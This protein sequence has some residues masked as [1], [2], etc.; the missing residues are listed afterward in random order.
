MRTARP[1]R[2]AMTTLRGDLPAASIL[3]VLLLI[4]QLLLAGL[5]AGA[6]LAGNEGPGERDLCTSAHRASAAHRGE[7][8]HGRECPCL[9]AGC[10]SLPVGAPPADA[11]FPERRNAGL[12]FASNREGIV[13]EFERRPLALF[14]RAGQGPPPA[15]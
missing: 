6:A 14:A 11:D 1:D 7:V 13:A 2:F 9:A 4:V 12:A 5:G 8:E 3:A 10:C 15:A